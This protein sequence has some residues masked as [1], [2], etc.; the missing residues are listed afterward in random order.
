ML[1]TVKGLCIQYIVL[2]TGEDLYSNTSYNLA[3][4]ETIKRTLPHNIYLVVAHN[5]TQHFYHV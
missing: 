5:L 2:E 3:L 4:V 1:C